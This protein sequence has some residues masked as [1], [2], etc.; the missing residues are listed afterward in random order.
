MKTVDPR[1]VI[2]ALREVAETI[3]LPRY[4]KLE[5]GQI[6][7]KASA[8]DV[9]TIADEESEQR[10]AKTL[11]DLVPGSVLIGEESVAKDIGLLGHIETEEWVWIVDPIDGTLNF[12]SGR[13]VFCTMAALVHKGVTQWGFIH[14]P[15]ANETIWAERGAGAFKT[16]EQGTTSALALKEP[17]TLELSSLQAAVYDKDMAPLK[18]KFA[19]VSRSGCAGHDYWAAAEGRLQVVS[20]RR[21]RP[22]DHAPGVL[23]YSEAGGYARLLSGDDYK[24][25]K[26]STIGLLCAPNEQTW[27][28][29]VATRQSLE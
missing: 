28:E 22:W 12:V 27:A 29:I 14:N 9:V 18:G 8:H 21:L 24:P 17:A 11:P 6:R 13:P 15:L 20:F 7:T 10:L 26:E 5:K 3:I 2:G 1:A 25:G 4:N 19:R 23:I 16:T